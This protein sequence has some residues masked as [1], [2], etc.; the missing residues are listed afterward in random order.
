M[1]TEL[2]PHLETFA[3]AAELNSFTAAARSLGLSQAA[4]SQRVQALEQALS[5]SLFNRQGG[6]IF[7]SEAGQCLY[8]YSQRIIALHQEARREI[9]GK[10]EPLVAQL[11]LAASSIPGEHLLPELLS[12]F[13]QKHPHVQIRVTVSDSAAVLSE[14]EQGQAQL[15]LVGAKSDHPSLEYRPFARD[16]MVLLTPPKH[17]WSRRKQVTLDQLCKEPL[18]VRETGSGSRDCLEQALAR[19]GK[20]MRDLNVVLELGSNEAIKEMVLR[21]GGL[22]VLSSQVVQKEVEARMLHALAVA[23]LE[24][25]RD[26]YAVWDKR[27]ALPIPAQLFLDYLGRDGSPAVAGAFG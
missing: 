24:L 1:K 20:S 18:I 21:G 26:L 2:L 25:E 9:T 19:A 5:V 11:S 16:V 3:R 4:V 14:V 10:R 7:L 15:G 23:D 12:G 22:A 6:Q 27:R 17:A 8:D 13:R